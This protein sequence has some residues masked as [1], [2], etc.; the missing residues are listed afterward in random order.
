MKFA[1]ASGESD[2]GVRAIDGEDKP[3]SDEKKD[4]EE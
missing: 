2:A 1:S 4:Y 3:R